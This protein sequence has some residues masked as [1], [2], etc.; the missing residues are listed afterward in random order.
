MNNVYFSNHY[1]SLDQDPLVQDFIAA[2]KDKYGTEPNA[3]HALGYDLGKFIADAIERA[4]STD[5]DAIRDALAETTT[6][7]L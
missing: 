2:F 1:S 7:S 5:P 4:G 3:F 6:L